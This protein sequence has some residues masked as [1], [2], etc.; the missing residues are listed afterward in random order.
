MRPEHGRKDCGRKEASSL[1]SHTTK[2]N[3]DEGSRRWLPYSCF[4]TACGA[5]STLSRVSMETGA[6]SKG[7]VGEYQTTAVSD[8]TA[9]TTKS[10]SCGLFLK[11]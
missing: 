8:L 2:E 1:E 5:A 9:N 6:R 4:R 11:S 10:F 3:A 7:Q